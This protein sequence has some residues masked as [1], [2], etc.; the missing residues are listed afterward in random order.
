MQAWVDAYYAE[1]GDQL[2]L[3]HPVTDRVTVCQGVAAAGP[4]FGRAG[5]IQQ[6]LVLDIQ[7]SH[8]DSIEVC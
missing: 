1:V 6:A 2:V 8:F 4:E 3:P 5:L 7:D